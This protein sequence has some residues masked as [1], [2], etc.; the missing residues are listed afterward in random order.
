MT[1]TQEVLIRYGQMQAGSDDYY[2]PQWV[3]DKLALRFDL[4]VC[5]PPGGVAWVPADRFYT[6]EDD[7]LSQPWEG[8][9]WMNP[10]YSVPGPWI[11]RF[12]AHRNGIALIAQAKSG[13]FGRIWQAADAIAV[14]ERFFPFVGGQIY[15]PT[16]FA[17]YGAECVEALS[18][19]G[20]VRT[21]PLPQNQEAGE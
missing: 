17:A 14:P 13:A 3:F 10:P 19:I 16:A 9:V 8:R 21:R 11:D 6:V 2:T 7:G 4:D 18:R 1:G 12:I 15:M 5:A 20:I